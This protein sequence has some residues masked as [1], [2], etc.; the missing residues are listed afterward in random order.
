MEV[1]G[2]ATKVLLVLQFQVQE[3]LLRF[4]PLTLPQAS[5]QQVQPFLQLQRPVLHLS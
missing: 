4:S 2:L 3:F 5:E 1:L